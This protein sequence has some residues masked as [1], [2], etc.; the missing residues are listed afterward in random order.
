M[1]KHHSAEM[2]AL[3][4]LNVQSSF[5]KLFG[6]AIKGREVG[7]SNPESYPGKISSHLLDP[8]K[9]KSE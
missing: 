8:S 2:P 4:F 1:Q 5:W 7:N 9:F 6:T 3:M